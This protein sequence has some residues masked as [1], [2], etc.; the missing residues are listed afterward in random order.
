MKKLWKSVM[1]TLVLAM[2]SAPMISA[3]D[4]EEKHVK[5]IFIRD[6]EVIQVDGSPGDMPFIETLGDRTYLGVQLI[7]ITAELRSHYRAPEDSGVLISAVS[8]D[9]PAARAGLR[10]GD[11]VL[12]IDGESVSSAGAVRRMIREREEGDAVEIEV[13]RSGNRQMVYATLDKKKLTLPRIE[14]GEHR[15]ALRY[16]LEKSDPSLQ[17][18]QKFFESP[19][20]EARVSRLPNCE[21]IQAKLEVMQERL[22]EMEK[23]LEKMK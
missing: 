16:E 13:I 3:D 12:S 20:W 19:E 9:S 2:L 5:R 8:D 21:E 15:K 1:F 10:A 18:L 7:D 14:L 11:V 6:G 22:E 23:R 4:G 17:K